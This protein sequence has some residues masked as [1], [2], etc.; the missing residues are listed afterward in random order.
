VV[1]LHEGTLADLQGLPHPWRSETGRRLTDL[2]APP[3][4]V[5]ADLDHSGQPQRFDGHVLHVATNGV[6]VKSKNEVIVAGI[7]D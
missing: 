5:T 3:K 4:P 7:L 6:V 1:I 2:F